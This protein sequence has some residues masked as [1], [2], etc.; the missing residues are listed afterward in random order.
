MDQ[1][2]VFLLGLLA[3]AIT[4]FTGKDVIKR[5]ELNENYLIV[6]RIL[7]NE[8]VEL[9]NIKSVEIKIKT[10]WYPVSV[11]EIINIVMKSGEEVYFGTNEIPKEIRSMLL[12]K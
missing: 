1:S 10:F 2:S 3:I 4:V 6:D 5:I 9:I 8:T 11:A 12:K 7:W